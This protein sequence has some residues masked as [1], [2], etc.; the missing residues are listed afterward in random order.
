M[1]LLENLAN[2]MNDSWQ[3]I[4]IVVMITGGALFG[5]YVLCLVTNESGTNARG[6]TKNRTNYLTILS[7]AVALVASVAIGSIC[8]LSVMSK[9]GKD[10]RK[11]DKAMDESIRKQ[12]EEMLPDDSDIVLAKSHGNTEYLMDTKNVVKTVHREYEGIEYKLVSNRSENNSNFEM[13]R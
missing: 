12:I 2:F 6:Y 8:A 10:Y 5:I 1:R 4:F 7:F 3:N 13:M 9:L 11:A